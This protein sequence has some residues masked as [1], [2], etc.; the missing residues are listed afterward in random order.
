[1]DKKIVLQVRF[2][3]FIAILLFLFGLNSSVVLARDITSRKI[4]VFKSD[5][6]EYSKNRILT[7]SGAEVVKHLKAAKSS[8]AIV[9]A[10]SLAKLKKNMWVLR[11]DDDVSVEALGKPAPSPLAETLPWGVE[12]VKAPDVWST[13]TASSIK[14]AILDTGIDLSHPDLKENI[15]GGYNAIKPF[16][17]PKDDNGHGTHV[18]GVIAAASNTFGVVGV[19]PQA[20]L[21]AVKVL[22]RN[23]G[24]YLSDVIEGLDWSIANGM[25]VVNMSLGTNSDIESFHEAVERAFNA[26]VVVVAA[27]GNDFGGGVNFPAAYP[28]VIAVSAVDVNNNLANFSSIG[29]EVDLAAPGVDIFS[30]YKGSTYKALNGTSMAA[31]HVAGVAALVMSK[32]YVCDYDFDGSCD[33]LEL[34]LHLELTATDLGEGGKDNSYG[35]GLV[36]AMAA[37]N[38]WY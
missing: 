25:N 32:P 24:G 15:K 16:S 13:T 7:N 8:V 20:N 2:A 37:L 14:V 22:D 18:A 30:T 26:G 6:T 12:A 10:D 31:P 21:Y 38:F 5:L 11:I 27:A 28:E 33:P 17:L 9:D 35:A 3:L 4:V 34:R 1:M 36:N 19:S 29:Q 23:G